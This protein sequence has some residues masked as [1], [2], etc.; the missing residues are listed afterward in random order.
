MCRNVV[1]VHGPFLK[2]RDNLDLCSDH[3]INLVEMMQFESIDHFNQFDN[4]FGKFLR[5]RTK[6]NKPPVGGTAVMMRHHYITTMGAGIPSS[7]VPV[8]FKRRDICFLALI[9]GT[10]LSVIFS[11]F[12][13]T[14]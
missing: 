1:P 12:C 5:Y 14:K 13:A 11:T 3:E 6:E 4:I 8:K 2:M 10:I 9:L 7:E